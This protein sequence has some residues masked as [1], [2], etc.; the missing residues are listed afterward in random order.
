[1]AKNNKIFLVTFDLLE[2]L[3]KFYHER[4]GISSVDIGYPTNYAIF[5]NL[6]EGQELPLIIV[7]KPIKDRNNFFLTDS[8]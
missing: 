4:C 1:M 2:G 5:K 8:F 6:L 7:K 3:T